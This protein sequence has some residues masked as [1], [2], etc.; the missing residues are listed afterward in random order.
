MKKYEH[1]IKDLNMKI[2]KLTDEA[3]NVGNIYH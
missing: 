1:T 2:E 3:M